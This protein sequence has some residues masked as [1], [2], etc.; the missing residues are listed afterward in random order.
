MSVGNIQSSVN[1]SKVDLKF[2]NVGDVI[3]CGDSEFIYEESD[4]SR[5]E[6]IKQKTGTSLVS[7]EHHESFISILETISKIIQREDYKSNLPS[8]LKIACD[9]MGGDH[10]ILHCQIN[11]DDFHYCYPDDSIQISQSA[12]DQSMEK[13]EAVLWNL[14]DDSKPF[15]SSMSITK[16]QLTSILTAPFKIYDQSKSNGYLYIQRKAQQK[17]FNQKDLT[18]FKEFLKVCELLIK[19]S[20][21]KQSQKNEIASLRGV[22]NQKGLIYACEPMSQLLQLAKKAA[23]MPVPILI[24]GETG[25]GK[26]VLA[27]LIHENSNRKEFKFIGVN[28]GAIPENLIESELFGHVKG[29]FTGAVE[30]KKGIFE[31]CSQGTLFLDEI[32]ELDLSLQVKLL[33]VLQE[34]KVTPVGSS[35]E[36]E[37]DVRI[38][39]AT[40]V[41]ID[42]AVE[43]KKFRE[44]LFF[45]INVMNLNIPP[46]R[47][48]GADVLLIAIEFLNK[49]CIEYGLETCQFSKAAEKSLMKHG[50][51]G[52]VRELENRVQKALIQVDEGKIEPLHLGLDKKEAVK[53]KRTL[54]EARENAER[55]VIHQVLTDSRANLTLA[56]SILGVDRKVLR[57]VM[58]RLSFKKEDY[59]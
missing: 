25:T 8:I 6:L 35:K 52:N 1:D 24:Q 45:R 26:E 38:I 51:P 20:W 37:V 16:N 42:K 9:T 17:S 28:C 44:D 13:K 58:E 54:K 48:R 4:G 30:N 50:W 3:K 47:A 10:G 46:L 14:E 21:E 22:Q 15:D 5:H 29:S 43:E 49:F 32:G 2:L 53:S 31:E 11:D 56:A 57:D 7:E 18:L 40:H 34:K 19:N 59:K 23:K 27:K 41:D 12:I 36:I 55:E 33:R 39:S